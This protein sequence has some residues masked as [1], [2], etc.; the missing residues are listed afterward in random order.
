MI[1]KILPISIFVLLVVIIVLLGLQ[2]LLNKNNSRGNSSITPTLFQGQQANGSTSQTGKIYVT[3]PNG[4]TTEKPMTPEDFQ[5]K[6]PIVA[7]DFTLDYSSRMQKYVVTLKNDK[8]QDAYNQWF[9]QNTSFDPLLPPAQIITSE[10]SVQ[11]LHSAL[12]YANNN[13]LSPE[14]AFK[15]NTDTILSIV[16]TLFSP[17]TN[18][19]Q[20]ITFPTI[21][22]TPSNSSKKPTDIPED[23]QTHSGSG[24]YIYYPQCGGPYDS[25][26]LPVQNGTAGKK[27]TICSAGCGPTTAAM[28]LSSYVDKTQTPPK[29]VEAMGKAGVNISC[30]GSGMYELYDYMSKVNG[31]KVSSLLSLGHA[32]A[33]EVVGDFRN[34]IKGGW[35]LFVLA[36]CKYGGHYFWVTDVTAD[37]KILSF[38]PAYGS[39]K[40]T[41]F[42]ENQYD[43]HPYYIYAFAVKKS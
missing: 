1:K 43:P 13:K 35:T 32:E 42:N 36:D 20:P 33:K 4:T 27:C 41:P 40:P 11:E 37:G 17:I 7:P 10:Q 30:N 18:I 16:N 5:K 2:N 38:D 14:Q 9:D 22:S 29:V 8:G 15:K 25:Y 23:L 6:L 21:T 19:Q 26:L 31:I 12:D 28:I 39:G 24:N 34:Y 3:N